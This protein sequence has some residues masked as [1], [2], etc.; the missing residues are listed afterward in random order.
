MRQILLGSELAPAHP[1]GSVEFGSWWDQYLNDLRSMRGFQEDS[2]QMMELTASVRTTLSTLPHPADWRGNPSPFKGLIVGSVQSGK[3]A[4][5]I[6]LTAAALDLGYR[7]VIVLA[8]KTNDLRSQTS[9]RFNTQLLQRSDEIPGRHGQTT[10]GGRPRQGPLGGCALPYPIDV[11]DF[12]PL[13]AS[14]DRA[15][16]A[17]E[18][19]VITIKKKE[20]SLIHLSSKILRVLYQ[21][22]GPAELPTLIL[23]DECDEASVPGPGETKV[24]PELIAGLWQ[25]R[26]LSTPPVAYVGYTEPAPVSRTACFLVHHAASTSAV[27]SL[28]YSTGLRLLIEV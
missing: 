15:L 4:N 17:G 19:C 28:S 10:L 26:G 16:R 5:M 21:R 7:I 12:G 22:H 9:L 25:H 11:A 14:M 3:T 18:P 24:I 2:P 27:Y 1:S 8:G 23:D 13:L 6:G 20:K